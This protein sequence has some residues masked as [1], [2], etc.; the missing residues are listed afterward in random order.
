LGAGLLGAV[1]ATT[2][3][4]KANLTDGTAT[5]STNYGAPP[6][7]YPASLAIDGN[8]GNFTHTS[9]GDPDPWWQV[10]F[11]KDHTFSTV[12]LHNRP[13][14]V[15]YAR[16]SD[17][18]VE[19]FDDAGN[20][21]YTS[22]VLN[23][24]NALGG[25]PLITLDIGS[26]VTGRVLKVSRDPASRPG[27]GILSLAEVE[28]G[29][30]TE[31]V[32]PSGTNLMRAGIVAMQMSQST[33]LGPAYPATN[34]ADGILDN[35]THTQDTDTDPWW[36]V[37]FGEVM[38]LESVT[39]YNRS[40]CCE[41]RLKDITIT[42]LDDTGAVVHQ[43]P[44]LITAG[45]IPLGGTFQYD[46]AAQNGGN[47]I[48][49]QTVKISRTPDPA[50]GGIDADHN[51]LSLAEV[52][53]YGGT[54]VSLD[55][56][57]DGM[58]D[59]W[60]NL[61]GTNPNLDDANE[62]TL[63]N[64]GLTNIQEYHAGTDPANA[65]TDGDGYGD[66]V[67]DKSGTWA[68]S[69]HTGTDPTNPDTDDDGIDDGSENPDTGTPA[70]PTFNSDPNL[71]DTDADGL[72]DGWETKYG[73]DSTDDGTT[74]VANGPDGD[75]D[76]D[77]LTTLD[78]YSADWQTD[79]TKAD[80]DD[81]GYNDNVEDRFKSWSAPDATGTDPT[82]PDSD[83]DGILDGNENPDTGTE[84]GP[85]YS[86]DPNIADTDA[87][88]I[89]DGEEVVEGE[90]GYITNPL[91]D[92]TDEDGLL[93]GEEIRYGTDPTDPAS[94]FASLFD[95][96]ITWQTPQNVTGLLDDLDTTGDLVKA[97]SASNDTFTVGGIDF[98][99]AT[100]MSGSIHK[101]FDPYDRG[102]DAD[103]EALIAT[104][105][106]SGAAQIVTVTGLTPGESYRIQIWVVDTRSC[107]KGRIRTFTT[108]TTSADPAQTAE[109]NSG[110]YGDET[111][112]PGQF[113]IG[114]FTA[115]S[116]TLR[117]LTDG[118]GGPQIN[119]MMVRRVVGQ[120]A[121][122]PKIL[123]AAFN[124]AAFE[125]EATGYD[126]T[127]QYQLKR[128]LDLGTFTDLGGPFTPTGPNYTVQDTAPPAGKAFYRIDETP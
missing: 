83:Y 2:I 115:K 13:S 18:T 63:D 62:D 127:K 121:Q 97:Y 19:V 10:D 3:L 34:A 40:N 59:V 67:E 96:P 32:I 14:A 8:L 17:I 53:I 1:H 87:D 31:A 48:L 108:D 5:Q 27:T 25:P 71:P 75:P 54:D 58:P 88:G 125:I 101:A 65:D 20:P 39:I 49:G 123:R 93:D 12:F 78:E 118:N 105:I 41:I 42:V 16:L 68:N 119:A 9:T 106:W 86:T 79:P 81:D 109:L 55:T 91:V 89:I 56:D 70:G 113:V 120:T 23:P 98:E 126:T 33:T 103:Y 84:T 116:D 77:T 47:P 26:E 74:D 94:N 6:Y 69:G 90:D 72:P 100:F 22:P 30:V 15:L 114:T 61:Y 36:Q 35:F 60:E 107:C 45:D 29:K 117:I 82:N 21:V 66:A 122:G 51:V 28:I 111:N 95:T 43:S 85:I 124:G 102:N 52:E 112:H 99:P 7:P 46:L 50:W 38:S 76:N 80:T 92:D 11:G 73:L 104:G 64:D 24:G 110:V 4:E 57:S 128:S 37:D 44:L